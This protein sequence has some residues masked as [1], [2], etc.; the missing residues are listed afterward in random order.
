MIM[1]N[2]SLFQTRH[3]DGIFSLTLPSRFSLNEALILQQML[4]QIFQGDLF[5]QKIV[6]DFNKTT[7]LDGFGV[8]ELAKMLNIARQKGIEFIVRNVSPS[9]GV[10]LSITGLE[11][12]LSMEV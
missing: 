7:F 2:S 11:F 8:L 1:H 9:I 4:R 5:I 3:F 12:F 10:V 6:L